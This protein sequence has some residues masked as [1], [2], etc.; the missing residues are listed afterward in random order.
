MD[1]SVELISGPDMSTLDHK[2]VAKYPNADCSADT[3][4]IAQYFG[5]RTRSASPPCSRKRRGGKSVTSITATCARRFKISPKLALTRRAIT[6]RRRRTEES[7]LIIYSVRRR[8][9][10]RWG[11]SSRFHKIE[12]ESL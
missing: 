12:G 3:L 2:R 1:Y 8:T 11:S 10:Q 4:D 7:S 9:S 5:T 6:S